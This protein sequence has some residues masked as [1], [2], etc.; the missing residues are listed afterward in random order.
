MDVTNIAASRP[1]VGTARIGLAWF[2]I[3]WLSGMASGQTVQ[4]PNQQIFSVGTSV[5]VPKRGAIQL[6]SVSRARE[7]SAARGLAGGGPVL[8]NRG[9]GRE[10]SRSTATAHVRIIDL[11]EMDREV[12]AA[13]RRERG[14]SFPAAAGAATPEQ[15]QLAAFLTRHMGRHGSPTAPDTSTRR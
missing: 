3:L 10:F 2:A 11:D 1:L 6:G 8:E 4:L 7:S 12:L 15:W 14:E 9:V 13:A 5:L